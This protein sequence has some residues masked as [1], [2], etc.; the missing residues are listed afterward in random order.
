M[1][2]HS[3]FS[4]AAAGCLAAA[5]AQPALAANVKITP[6][7]GQEGELC[8][9]DRAM[10]FEDPSGTRVLYDPGRTVA[11]AGDPRLGK[12]D[13]ILV[14]HMHGDHVGN[15]H[16]AAPNSGACDKPDM[17]VSAMPNSNV[18]NIALA[19]NAR[20]VTGS[21]MPPFFANKLKA[22]GGDPKNS[23]LARFGASVKIGGV[24]IATVPAIH[25]NGLDP[26]FI[27]GELGKHMKDAGIAGYVGEA[28]GYVLKFS[29]GLVAYLSGD[30]GITGEQEKVVRGHYAARLTV[31]NIGDTFTTGP[32]EAAYVINELVRPVSVILSHVNEV[33]TR[34]G[35]VL[36]GT[37]TET[38]LKAVKVPAHV[39]L[40]GRTMEFDGGGKCV[41]GC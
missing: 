26:D 5:L 4:L 15:S 30:T 41:A 35:K 33:A 6:L 31:M 28:T 3:L 1:K 21:E 25:S 38:F 9:L 18:V 11:G 24:T 39:P 20:I 14:S 27:G 36:P 13:V 19:K 34:G 32:T 40:S 7:G 16:N 12:I 10:I 29:N 2:I 22:N 23:V 37:R 17:S 8:P